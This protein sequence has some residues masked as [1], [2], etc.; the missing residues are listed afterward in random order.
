ME[1]AFES[2]G[3]NILDVGSPGKESVGWNILDVGSPG[4][5]SLFHPT[6]SKVFSKC[7][8]NIYTSI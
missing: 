5:D 1:N 4:K 3:W 2:V 7:Q 8:Y 6:D